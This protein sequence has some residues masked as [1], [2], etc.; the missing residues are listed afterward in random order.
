MKQCPFCAEDIQEN[1]VKCKFCGEWL[2]NIAHPC[3]QCKTWIRNSDVECPFCG[4]IHTIDENEKIPF[5]NILK[6]RIN[7]IEK[8]L[9]QE[10]LHECNG[11]VTKTAKELGISRKG[12]QLKMIQYDLREKE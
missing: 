6:K 11:N 2:R 4:Y 1:A 9:I 12:L 7:E 8:Q 10:V 3:K 5:K